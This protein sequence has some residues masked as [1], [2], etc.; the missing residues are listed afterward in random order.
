MKKIFFIVVGGI[1]LL[2][3]ATLPAWAYSIQNIQGMD[4]RNDFIVGPPKAEVLLDPGQSTYRSITITNRHDQEMIFMLDIEDFTGSKNSDEMIELLGGEK[5]P[6]SLKDYLRPEVMEFK[7]QPGDRIS[8]PVKI[9]IP[10]DATPGGLYGAVI[11]TTEPADEATQANKDQTT[12][13]LKIKSR[14][15]SLFFVRVSGEVKESGALKEFKTNKKYFEKGPIVFSY[16]FENTGSIWL[17]T[18]GTIDILNLYGSQVDHL[19]LTP[20]TIMPGSIRSAVMQWNRDFM[21]GRYKATI[22]LNR[23]SGNDNFSKTVYFWVLP[24]KLVTG[25]IIGLIVILGIIRWIILWLKKNFKIT[26]R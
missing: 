20:M 8:L 19:D 14:I 13:G 18:S 23:A 1:F 25:I 7:L 21:L 24:W 2:L 4:M 11:V 16:S 6:Y 17:N 3:W 10:K 22:N 5:G 15:A 26:K 9:S 12:G